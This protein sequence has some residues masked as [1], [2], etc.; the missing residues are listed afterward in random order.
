MYEKSAC[1]R[2]L[3]GAILRLD[4]VFLR[5]SSFFIFHSFL[6]MKSVVLR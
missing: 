6:A 2:S 1:L 3:L 5:D 4:S